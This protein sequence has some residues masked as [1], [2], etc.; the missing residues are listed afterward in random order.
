MA[1]NPER[2]SS[3]VFSR[4]EFLKFV[5]AAG[6]GAVLGSC[7]EGSLIP[8]ETKPD[9]SKTPFPTA[10][11]TLIPLSSETP[12]VAMV[13]DSEAN[14]VDLVE[15]YSLDF[16]ADDPYYSWYCLNGGEKLSLFNQKTVKV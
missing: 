7:R 8:A 2:K 5:G 10:F 14:L 11:P 16:S 15:K 3:P 12:R 9:F 4:R 13:L 6:L 1:N